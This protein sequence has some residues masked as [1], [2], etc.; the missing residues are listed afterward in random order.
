VSTTAPRVA[1]AVALPPDVP[2]PPAAPEGGVRWP[3]GVVR[4]PG[5]RPPAADVPD[6]SAA[7][8]GAGLTGRWR[9]LIAAVALGAAALGFYA[10]RR[11]RRR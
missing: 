7:G 4:P 1:F 9:T 3:D 11:R 10:V 2:A 8:H 5:E 6:P